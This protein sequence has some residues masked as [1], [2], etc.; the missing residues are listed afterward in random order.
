[1][2]Q[3]YEIQGSGE[4]KNLSADAIHIV[5]RTHNQKGNLPMQPLFI[6]LGILVLLAV[7][8]VIWAIGTFNSLVELRNRVKNSFAQ[9][10][11]QLKR[12]Y[13]LIPNLIEVAKKFMAHERETLEAVTQARNLAQSAA[14][15][16]DPTDP[17]SMKSL[18]AAESG[19]GGALGRLIAVS[20]SYPDLKSNVNM[21]QL[22]EELTATENK[23]AFS[24]QA[25]N[26]SV[27][28]YNNKRESFPASIIASMKNFNPA[29]SYE[30]SDEERE[31]VRK[32]IDVKFD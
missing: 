1:M 8:F 15:S 7:F 28:T 2:W 23:V 31:E 9:I 21:L 18:M 5:Q 11:V 29:T 17:A 4:T 13:D 16:A 6:T 25:Y 24:R 32:G 22:Q 12:R 14:K 27:L 3:N 10:D 30:V 19:L 20:E 26:D